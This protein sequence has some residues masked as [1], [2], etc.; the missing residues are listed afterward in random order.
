MCGFVWSARSALGL[1][2]GGIAVSGFVFATLRL[3]PLYD[4]FALW[5]VPALYAGIALLVDRAVSSARAAARDGKW[6]QGGWTIALAGAAILC[7]AGI[8]QRGA[9]RFHMDRPTSNHGVDDRT[10]VSWLIGHRQPGDALIS[11]RLGLPAVWWYGRISIAGVQDMGPVYQV[12]HRR[13]GTGCGLAAVLKHHR[14]VLVY[15]GFPDMPKGFDELLFAELDRIG[16]ISA[17]REDA[18]LSRAAVVDL[19]AIGPDVSAFVDRESRSAID[20]CVGI[21]TA[22]RR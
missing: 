20:G 2:F 3:V 16:A 8:V 13:Q 9:G 14:R 11:T 10:A 4:R 6:V 18:E 1:V 15:V 21:R 17:Y 7:S 22:V 19:D 12:E 5:M